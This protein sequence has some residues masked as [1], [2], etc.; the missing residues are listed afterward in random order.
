MIFCAEIYAAIDPEGTEDRF[1]FATEAF[2]TGTGGSPQDTP[3]YNRLMQPA[4]F[5]RSI[6]SGKLIFGLTET[7]YGE[8]VI[9]NGT[10]ALAITA[11]GVTPQ[12]QNT[13]SSSGATG[14]AS[15]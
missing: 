13:G 4:N 15:P 8:C 5:E 10:F 14:T 11:C 1:L 12:A 3:A 7:G 6:A 9:A 2:H